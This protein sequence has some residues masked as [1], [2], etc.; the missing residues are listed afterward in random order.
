MGNSTVNLTCYVDEMKGNCT[1]YE[2]TVIDHIRYVCFIP[3][4]LIVFVVGLPSNILAYIVI[5][6][7][8]PSSVTVIMKAL[9]IA[10]AVHITSVFC[11]FPRFIPHIIELS[12]RNVPWIWDFFNLSRN[13]VY[14]SLRFS[15]MIS[16]YLIIVMTFERFIAVLFPLKATN[17]C[18][19]RNSRICVGIICVFSLLYNSPKFYTYTV[20]WGCDYCLGYNRAQWGWSE[21]TLNDLYFHIYFWH[22]IWVFFFFIPLSTI[23]FLNILIIRAIFRASKARSEMTSTGKQ[24][25]QNEATRKLLG[26]VFVFIL[27]ELPF[28]FATLLIDFGIISQSKDVNVYNLIL[29]LGY[30]A[31]AMNS[32]VNLFIYALVGRKFR[33]ILIDTLSCWHTTVVNAGSTQV[34]N[35]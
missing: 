12:L 22:M 7:E 19:I 8:R 2:W 33:R 3:V 31:S 11:Y 5:S 21:L 18:S 29:G 26:V 16:I 13:V 10:D 14:F 24:Q 32:S 15:K 30:F 6:K 25:D 27:C 1:G 20:F 9:S 17:Y 28:S 23:S 4:L 34:T 35:T